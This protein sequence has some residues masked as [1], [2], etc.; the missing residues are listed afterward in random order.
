MLRETEHFDSIKV[1]MKFNRCF[2]TLLTLDIPSI[3]QWTI[4]DPTTEK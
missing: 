2:Q 4:N 3:V 1:N